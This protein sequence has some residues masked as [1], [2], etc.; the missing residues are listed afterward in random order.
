MSLQQWSVM[1]C[2]INAYLSKTLQ[3]RNRTVYE[4]GRSVSQVEKRR[5][6]SPSLFIA[7]ARL[8]TYSIVPNNNALHLF[9][10]LKIRN[11]RAKMER[12]WKGEE[13]TRAPN[14][15]ETHDA[16]SVSLRHLLHIISRAWTL[17][18]LWY[19]CASRCNLYSTSIDI[20]YVGD[21]L[22]YAGKYVCVCKSYAYD[23]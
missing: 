21:I 8:V 22:L 10:F 19:K 1:F 7:V 11:R 12:I 20:T 13:N 5:Q 16:M 17:D 14:A 2:Q 4:E 3:C 6:A 9:P 15:W 18:S 23:T